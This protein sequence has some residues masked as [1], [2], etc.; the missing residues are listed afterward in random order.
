MLK[1][2]AWPTDSRFAEDPIEDPIKE[3]TI[4][5][6]SEVFGFQGPLLRANNAF[7]LESF[8]AFHRRRLA[9][10]TLIRTS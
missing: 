9:F 7:R 10:S 4:C 3:L 8:G 2:P 5:Y 1:K 6:G